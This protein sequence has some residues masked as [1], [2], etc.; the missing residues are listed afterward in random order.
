MVKK[1]LLSKNKH[2][3]NPKYLENIQDQADL[4]AIWISEIF[5]SVRPPIWKN[6]L[7]LNE[8]LGDFMHFESLHLVDQLNY[9]SHLNCGYSL[10]ILNF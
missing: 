1:S 5:L 3:K 6:K 7:L 2:W 9:I 10:S 4:A 8:Y